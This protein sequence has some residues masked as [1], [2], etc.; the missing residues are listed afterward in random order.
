MMPPGF[1]GEDVDAQAAWWFARI[2]SGDVSA[3]QRVAFDAWLERDPANAA[4]SD[5]YSTLW[6]ILGEV[7]DEPAMLERRDSLRQPHRQPWRYAAAA[8]VMAGAVSAAFWWPHGQHSSTLPSTVADQPIATRFETGVG[9]VS[10]LALADG[11]T[12]VLDTDSVLKA[13]FDGTAR[14]I[15]LLRGRAFFH[16]AHEKRLFTVTGRRLAVT[17]T[18]TQFVVDL[19]TAPDVVSMIEGSVIAANVDP[20]SGQQIALKAGHSL[21]AGTSGW[22]LGKVDIDQA[23]GWTTGQLTFRNAPLAD[24]VRETNRYS[25]RKI[26]LGDGV[27][28]TR[29]SAV[30]KAGDVDTLVSAVEDLGI[31]RVVGRDA[32][33]ITL[34]RR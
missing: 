12:V 10:R 15:S 19:D 32:G 6:S 33:A 27:G 8:M 2:R 28:R 24:V 22:R 1:P 17:A 5:R 3:E 14:R 31:A 13:E 25:P 26:V 9:Q 30:L 18:G 16:V 4:A 20:K 7:R 29:L 21:A 23:R 34:S 11:S